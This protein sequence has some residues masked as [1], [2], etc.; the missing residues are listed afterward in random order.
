MG[1]LERSGETS[2]S[3]CHYESSVRLCAVEKCLVAEQPAKVPRCTHDHVR[4]AY[5]A[6]GGPDRVSPALRAFSPRRGLVFQG[7]SGTGLSA[8]WAAAMLLYKFEAATPFQVAL[9]T[10]ETGYILPSE[11]APWRPNGSVDV[12]IG[13][14]F[15]GVALSEILG[16]IER[17]G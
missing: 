11:S 8:S 9:T 10:D 7:V 17:S 16:T 4:L 15:M 1:G 6:C 12:E 2:R 3:G 5:S 14:K 13:D